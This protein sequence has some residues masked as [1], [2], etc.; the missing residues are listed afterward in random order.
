MNHRSSI[1]LQSREETWISDR[2]ESSVEVKE[3]IGTVRARQNLGLLPSISRGSMRV[4]LCF[5]RLLGS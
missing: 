3:S 1:D 2:L 4:S 5:T